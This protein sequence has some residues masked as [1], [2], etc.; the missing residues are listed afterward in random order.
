MSVG[1]KIARWAVSNDTGMSSQFLAACALGDPDLAEISYPHDNGDFGRC[2]RLTRL[3]DTTEMTDA[4]T[5]AAG[6][7]Q[8]WAAIAVNWDK[9]CALY[10]GDEANDGSDLYHYMKSIE[11]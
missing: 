2:Y 5:L 3:L 8:K 1:E 7:S 10:E 9:L 4:L 6:C 11:L